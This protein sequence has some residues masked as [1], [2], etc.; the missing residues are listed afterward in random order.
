MKLSDEELMA[1]A[2]G[3]L[4]PVEAKRIEAAMAGDPAL[5]AR[6]ARFRAVRAALRSAY[7]SVVSE[8]VPEHLRALLGDVAAHEPEQQISS[9][10]DLSV[11]REQRQV[12]RFGPP[13]WAAMAASLV[14][15]VLVGRTLLTPDEGIFTRDG[16][17]ANAGLATALDTQLAAQNQDA[18]TRIGL[19]FRSTD[20]GVCRTFA[21]VRGDQVV[22]GLACRSGERWAVRTTLTEARAANGGFR[23]A[24]ADAPAILEAVDAIIDGAPFDAAQ[25]RQ[26]RDNG[27]TP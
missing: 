15:G 9:V 13:A 4:P 14:V 2:D 23:Q 19:T 6:V 27:W 21:N 3:E 24:D 1:Y 20:G 7:D 25:E 11:E 10:I 5:A 16:L 17:Y 22:S 18:P 26:A 12:R 8:P